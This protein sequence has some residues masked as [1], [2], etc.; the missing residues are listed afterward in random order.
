MNKLN[1]V[2]TIPT[3]KVDSIEFIKSQFEKH[4]SK[5]ALETYRLPNTT[6]RTKIIIGLSGG[7]DSSVLALF[8][9]VY[10]SQWYSDIEFIFTD[11]KQEPLSCYQT[12]DQIERLTGIKL[13]RI[14][15]EKG[16][17]EMVEQYNGFLPSSRARWCTKSL[18]VEP[19]VKYIKELNHHNK[20]VDELIEEVNA[21]GSK[22][23][24]DAKKSILTELESRKISYLNLAGIRSDEEDREGIQFQHSMENANSAYPFVDLGMTKAMVFDILHNTIGIPSTYAYRSRSGCYCCFFQR[25]SEIIGMLM[26]DPKA[27]LETESYE[28]LTEE[29]EKRWSNIPNTISESGMPAFYP[30]PAF[31]DIRKPDK[32]PFKAPVKLKQ[33]RTEY[34]ADLFEE[35]TFEP[36]EKGDE[37]YVAYALYVDPYLGWFGGGEFTP[38]TYWMEFVT[39]STSMAGIKS[40]LGNYYKFKKTTPMPQYDANDMK[41]V[42]AQLKF[43]AGTIDT[44]PPAK[45]SFT[46]K[47]SVAYKQLR[48]LA[49]HAQLTLEHA[50]LERRLKDAVASCKHSHTLNQF[51]N[52]EELVKSIVQQLK[53]A[54]AATG[55]LTWEGLYSPSL[56]VEKQVQLQLD[57]V[58]IETEIKPAR[59][60][61]E[62]DE[63]PMACISCSI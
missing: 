28:K 18:K 6:R 50:D 14:I 48:H 1:E 12:L 58:S 25:N 26:N 22:E 56:T 49:K 23:L 60:N 9:Y 17:F 52:A 36:L 34:V 42:I 57:G 53:A 38:G 8:A 33:Q 35:Q 40:A 10:L 16:L 32:A 39:V 62:F 37:L 51:Y 21:K 54:P 61:L 43:P 55:K 29:D 20:K 5:E 45:E 13:K 46:W 31:I 3:I 15:P 47:S 44:K 59:E 7:G 30:V 63:V 27:F 4:I 24:D 19:L 11:T 2:Q 41:I